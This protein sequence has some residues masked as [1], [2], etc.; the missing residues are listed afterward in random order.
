[1][2]RDVRLPM[3]LTM[4][5]GS[6]LREL[7]HA[8]ETW[9]IYDSSGFNNI[10]AVK[11]ELAEKWFESGLMTASAFKKINF[12]DTDLYALLSDKAHAMEP[13]EKSNPTESF[14]DALSFALSLK[15][16]RKID[17]DSSFHDGLFV[18]QHSRILPTFTGTR[19]QN[20]K[21]VLGSYLTGGVG[22]SIDTKIRATALISWMTSDKMNQLIEVS[23]LKEKR[24]SEFGGEDRHRD[25]KTTVDSPKD[26]TGSNIDDK[27]TIAPKSSKYFRLPGREKLENFF[28]EYVVDIVFNPVDYRVMGIDFPSPVILHGPPG[29]GKTYA[30]ESLADFLDWPVFHI[31]SESVGSSYIHETGKKISKVFDDAI[32]AAPSI[33]IMDE[34]ESFLS[35][36]RTLGN[37]W[38]HHIEEVG[39][40]LKRIPE[41]PK[42]Q[43]L[44][45]AMT[46]MIESI[47]KAIMRRGRFD[48]VIEVPMPTAK[49][50]AA[51]LDFLMKDLPK[52]DNLRLDEIISHLSGRPLSEAS[53][54]IREASRIAAKSS[55]KSITQADLNTAL[56]L[57]ILSCEIS[58]IM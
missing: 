15:E 32:S 11:R 43:V 52:S 55:R 20:D 1:M 36:R 31:N 29:C 35:D 56:T 53:F 16:S 21:I 19:P 41:A 38:I 34:M 48:H 39:E 49:E 42:H 37:I 40:F 3:G 44:I 47:D 24:K 26:D 51:L 22:V 13:V 8:G 9:Q 30:V 7:K 4:P 28:N 17:G 2:S 33:I 18:E 46:N 5:D 12:G 50:I 58:D 54:L 27:E 25:V 45:F 10:L 6:N 57:S 14:N 23:G